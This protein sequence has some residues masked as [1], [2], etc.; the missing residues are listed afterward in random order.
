MSTFKPQTQRG[1]EEA[2]LRQFSVFLPNRVGQLSELLG[3]LT[4][5]G[6]EVMGVC[7]VDSTDWAVVRLVFDDPDKGREV[8]G[9]HKLAFTEC[10]ALGLVLA[11]ANTLHKACSALLLAELSVQ[12]AYPLLIQSEGRPVMVLH[13]DDEVTAVRMLTQHGFP[14]IGHEE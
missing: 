2:W 3:M 8:L 11:D 9:R 5:E 13:V 1:R 7:V 12:F 14:M 4:T 6:I 10:D